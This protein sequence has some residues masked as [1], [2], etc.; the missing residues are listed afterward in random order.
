MTA[1]SEGALSL[2]EAA[3]R[4]HFEVAP[5]RASI[6]FLGVE[7][8]DILRYDDGP[9][10]HLL[11]LGM[12]RYPMAPASDTVVDAATAPRGEVMVTIRAGQDEVWRRLAI[13]AAAPA[14]EGAVYGVGGR[15][16]L[17]EPLVPGSRCVGGVLRASGL[18]PVS[19][20]GI[21]DIEIFRFIP[22]T[23]TELAWAKVHGT[24]ALHDR[25]LAHSVDL[26]DLFRDPVD[27]G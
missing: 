27:L 9:E 19:V 3:Y 2:V 13:L 1:S 7:P 4:Q 10:S 24:Q 6:S 26:S 8:I 20:E 11:S 14:V 5:Q 12:A 15:V 18:E 22:A 17:G 16:D 25:W 21:A 23:A